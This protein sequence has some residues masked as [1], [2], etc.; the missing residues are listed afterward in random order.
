MAR[1]S[2]GRVAP[3]S[4]LLHEQ[5]NWN[6]AT[7]LRAVAAVVPDRDAISCSG[8]RISF[9][10]FDGRTDQLALALQRRG[11]GAG[12]KVAIDLLN[13]PEYLEVFYAALKLGAV[14]V[15][16]NYRYKG[17]ELAYLLDYVD[18]AAIFVH[19][20]FLGSLRQA[21]PSLKSNV[22][23]VVVPHGETDPAI[24]LLRYDE[25]LDEG[26]RSSGTLGHVPSG[27][28]LIFVCTGGTTGMPKAVMWRNDD[29]YVS[30][31]MLSR[32]G[33]EPPDPG[34]AMR[35]AKR[36]G[37]TLPGP[38][39]MHGTG[40]YAALATLSGGGC[41]V[42]I[43]EPGLDPN[44]IWNEIAGERVQVLTIVGD[45]FARPLLEALDALDHDVDVDIDVS[46]LKVISSSGTIFSAELKAALLERLPNLRIVD[47]LGAT[48]GMISR[49]TATR[50]DVGTAKF[51]VSERVGVFSPEGQPIAPGSGKPGFLGVTGRLPVGYFKDPEKTAATFPTIH[52]RRYSIAGD[53]ATV[54]HDGTIVFLGRGSATINTGGEKVFPEEV[55]REIRDIVEVVD[56]CVVGVP[57]ERWG[58]RVVAVAQLGRGA[59]MTGEQIIDRLRMSLAG[60][61]VPKAVVLVPS[62]ERGPNGKIDYRRVTEM[63]SSPA[64]PDASNAEGLP[65]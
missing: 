36:A 33:T 30:Q 46:C 50:G 52:G 61:K 53:M 47:S 60:Y 23:T 54:E 17:A 35:D 12:A 32:P 65:S 51:M 19:G 41:V 18:A 5:S 31:W 34:Q 43:D 10:E 49:S 1:L 26:R 38:P 11:I 29:L 44:R 56:C 7:V 57:D 42:L 55:E 48:E 45:V 8:R 24:D 2:Q 25:L 58:Q 4:T 63:A 14:P 3:D 16:V 15:N 62:L 64:R 28:D 40:L 20:E 59:A 39:L 13:A 22:L 37:T 21:L 6:Y 9:A 27:D